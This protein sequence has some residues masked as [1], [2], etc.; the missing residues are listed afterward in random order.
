MTLQCLK[1]LGLFKKATHASD[2]PERTALDIMY[3]LNVQLDKDILAFNTVLT[4][5]QVQ[6]ASSSTKINYACIWPLTCVYRYYAQNLEWVKDL[7]DNSSKDSSMVELPMEE[8]PSY[9]DLVLAG[10][11]TIHTETPRVKFLDLPPLPKDPADW[12]L[13]RFKTAA[14]IEGAGGGSIISN[15][16][17]AKS[18]P[19]ASRVVKAMLVKAVAET[20][21]YLNAQFI[22]PE[23]LANANC[24]Y[25]TWQSILDLFEQGPIIGHHLDQV[26]T[27]IETCVCG[28]GLAN[29]LEFTKL[30]LSL[31]A[32]FNSLR[33]I[34][35][36]KEF[37][38]STQYP[39]PD[40][41]SKYKN[42]IEASSNGTHLSVIDASKKRT[43]QDT[44][45]YLYAKI[46]KMERPTGAA[47]QK[48]RSHSE[49]GHNS[50]THPNHGKKSPQQQQ[51]PSLEKELWNKINTM[52][53]EEDKTKVKEA[54]A[55]LKSTTKG[56][57]NKKRHHS[58]PGGNKQGKNKRRRGNMDTT[59]G[60][61]QTG[62]S[63]DHDEMN[64]TLGGLFE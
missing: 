22:L 56:Q 24:G 57:G 58:N 14:M 30:F 18:Y 51:R 8:L 60:K 11:G 6:P 62:P 49:G 12:F 31:K 23:D 21:G 25:S 17:H 50:G 28:E 64:L 45:M 39:E 34:A 37:I 27:E 19:E 29:W 44:I 13:W 40:W 4:V 15:P 20:D 42:R 36:E 2:S 26:T 43:L 35:E 41:N 10:V 63:K 52:S 55:L 38:E 16:I 5:S 32:R 46:Q 3:T 33:L 59:K 1:A 47:R 48:A 7:G 53:N 61:S 54:M 9:T